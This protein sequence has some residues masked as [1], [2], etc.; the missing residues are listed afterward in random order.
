VQLPDREL[1]RPSLDRGLLE[2]IAGATG[3]GALFPA[4]SW[5]ADD[6][7]RLAAAIPDRSR[8]EYETGAADA[9][10]KRRLNA[11]LLA[12][13]IGCLCLEWIVRRLAKLA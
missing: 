10:F 9:D 13:G 1:A 7:T 2:R 4:R 8:R 5:T 12:A 3:G 6:A 11:A